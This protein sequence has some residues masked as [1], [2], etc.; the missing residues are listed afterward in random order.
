MR[1]RCVI[2]MRAR[3]GLYVCRK[4]GVVVGLGGPSGWCTRICVC[5][6]V[7]VRARVC[8]CVGVRLCVCVSVLACVCVFLAAS[9]MLC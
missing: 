3:A 7:C 5:M 9:K 2:H 8:V 4:S 1:M 6:C